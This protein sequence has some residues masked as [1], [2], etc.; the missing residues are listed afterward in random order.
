MII[1]GMLFQRCQGCVVG[2]AIQRFGLMKETAEIYGKQ[3]N[4]T[5]LIESSLEIYRSEAVS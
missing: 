1:T 4:W 5:Y 3:S 2:H